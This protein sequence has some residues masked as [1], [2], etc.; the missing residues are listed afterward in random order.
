M[1]MIGTLNMLFGSI[2]EL[3]ELGKWTYGCLD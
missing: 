3:R 1:N 2:A